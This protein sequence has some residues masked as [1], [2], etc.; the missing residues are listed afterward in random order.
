MYIIQNYKLN[1]TKQ[2][3]YCDKQ[4][5]TAMPLMIVKWKNWL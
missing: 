4:G 2:I 5:Q 3:Y 1:K